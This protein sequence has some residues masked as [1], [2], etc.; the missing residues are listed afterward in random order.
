MSIQLLNFGTVINDTQT[1]ASIYDAIKSSLSSNHS[2]VEIDFSG[3]VTMAT[4]CAKQIFG[5]LYVELG[6][7][8]FFNKL[9]LKNASPELRFIIR[10]GI[11][12]ALEDKI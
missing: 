8:S 10:T 11:E 4:F 3:V 9:V 7:E 5:K 6:Q 1:G 2:P 12:S